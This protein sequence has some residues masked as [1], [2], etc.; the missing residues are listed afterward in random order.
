MVQNH[1]PLAVAIELQLVVDGLVVD[2]DDEVIPVRAACDFLPH[3]AVCTCDYVH[4]V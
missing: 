2:K 1:E 3:V 4:C